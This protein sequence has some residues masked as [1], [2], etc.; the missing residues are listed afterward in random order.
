MN[1]TA[2][3]VLA[4]R[5]ALVVLLLALILFFGLYGPTGDTFGSMANMRSVL[6]NQSVVAVASLA[7][8]VPL[9]GGQFDVSIGAVV[10][11]SS[12]IAASALEHGWPLMAA[13]ALAVGLSGLIGLIN[14]VLVAYVGVN[15]FIITLA[16]GT[17]IG[18]V[19]SLYT[20]N[21]IIVSGIPTSLTDFGSANVL[22]LP[23]VTWI[24]L[25]IAAVLAFVIGWTVHGRRLTSVG[26][27]P[28]A[29]RLVGIRVPS[30]VASSF[31]ISSML[32]GV[33]GVVL[34][35]RT[36]TGNPQIGSGYTLAAL[37]AAFLGATALK[38]GQFNVLGTLLGVLFVAVSVNGLTLAGAKSWVD[39]IFNGAAL[40]IAVALSTVLGRMRAR[41]QFEIHPTPQEEKSDD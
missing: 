37:S 26:A 38:P 8:T 33:A 31:V 25:L 23:W 30:V 6:G 18:G 5:Y 14:G 28:A 13:I 16:A 3:V 36:G 24:V 32:A 7:A 40:M 27:S 1:G 2:P 41:G 15:S 4:E 9:I 34:L 35:S 11:M 19:I 17:L 12:I 10:G 29:A 22:G 20:D 21:R 39:P